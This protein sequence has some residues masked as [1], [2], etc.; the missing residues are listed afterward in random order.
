MDGI[1]DWIVMNLFP[2]VS[3]DWRLLSLYFKNQK[4][5]HFVQGFVPWW[6]VCVGWD[7]PKSRCCG[8][9]GMEGY[10]KVCSFV[11]LYGGGW[12]FVGAV[13]WECRCGLWCGVA[14]SAAAVASHIG[15]LRAAWWFAVY[16]LR[17]FAPFYRLS[18]IPPLNFRFI[19]FRMCSPII[20]SY[21]PV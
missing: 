4:C 9:L 10:F 19:F 11:Y 13:R 6:T 7:A 14:Y 15:L 18:I 2:N 8:P 17:A 1:P 21:V 12:R 5:R 16:L 3:N 20:K